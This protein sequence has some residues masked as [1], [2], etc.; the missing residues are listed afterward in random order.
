[1]KNR[2]DGHASAETLAPL[3]LEIVSWPTRALDLMKYHNFMGKILRVLLTFLSNFYG[4]HPWQQTPYR[5]YFGE[6]FGIIK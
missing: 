5:L 2:K 4:E 6:Y 3:A 1:M